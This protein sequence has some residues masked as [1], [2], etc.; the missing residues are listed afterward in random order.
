M[1]LSSALSTSWRPLQNIGRGLKFRT[2]YQQFFCYSLH[3]SSLRQIGAN[4]SDANDAISTS[5]GWCF[6][7]F[8]IFYGRN[9]FFHALSQIFVAGPT[10]WGS[11]HFSNIYL[12]SSSARSLG[13][14]R[15]RN[16]FNLWRTP[17]A[18]LADEVMTKFLLLQRYQSWVASVSCL[19]HSGKKGDMFSRFLFMKIRF[20]ELVNADN[21]WIY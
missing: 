14:A 19:E 21:I 1:E 4:W 5:N 3:E 11:P 9:C 13:T 16:L 18:E 2:L 12:S 10:L 20:K 8:W 6:C 17:S 15:A 7:V